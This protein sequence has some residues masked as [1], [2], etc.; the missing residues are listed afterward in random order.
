VL[1]NCGLMVAGEAAADAAAAARARPEL[2][3]G[4]H[5]VLVCGR[6]ALSP[7]KIPRLV[8]AGGCFSESPTRVGVRL[9]LDPAARRE[10]RAE[11]EEQFARFMATGLPLS[12]VDG[13]LHFHLHPAV[14]DIVVDV[15]ERYGCRRIRLPQD[16]LTRHLRAVG[17][18]GAA[19][20]P[21]A[22]V[23][24]LLLGRARA[25]LRERR[26]RWPDRVYGFLQ[27]GRLDEGYVLRLIRELPPGVSELYLHP[28]TAP[29][30]TGNGPMELALLQS[31]VVRTALE[32]SG[33]HRI[34]YHHLER[35]ECP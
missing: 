30:P 10:L 29:G 13:H 18:R 7:A 25:R 2:G 5:L 16:D 3:V 9:A 27:T 32:A 33:I 31:G 1:T 15:A 17:A 26:F 8:A 20:A 4:L 12:H 21:L 24:A 19:A 6:P 34:N 23:F 22:A 28:D 11:I 14:F 35:G